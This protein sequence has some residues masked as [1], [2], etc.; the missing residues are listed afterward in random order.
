MASIFDSS[1]N[2]GA[3]SFAHALSPFDSLSINSNDF[4]ESSKMSVFVDEQGTVN[5]DGELRLFKNS[6]P[7]DAITEP[8]F[9]KKNKFIVGLEKALPGVPP[10]GIILY[11]GGSRTSP[12]PP[13]GFGLCDGRI[14][15]LNGG[16]TWIAPYILSI[17][18]GAE[19]IVRLP[20][21]A[22][23]TG[24]RITPPPSLSS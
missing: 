10:G 11:T 15:R 16:G 5:V 3:Q 9:S 7:I 21:G 22:V 12:Q 8:S 24:G 19:W 13:S 6:D 14:Y 1:E 2:L 23:S 4:V 17:A 20:E 18:P